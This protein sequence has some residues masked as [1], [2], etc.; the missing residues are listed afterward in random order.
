[1]TWIKSDYDRWINS[2][3]ILILEVNEKNSVVATYTDHSQEILYIGIS[4][5][6]AEV[7]LN[8]IVLDL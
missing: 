3:H 8:N 1:M 7:Y 6:D 5:T 2:V 4:K